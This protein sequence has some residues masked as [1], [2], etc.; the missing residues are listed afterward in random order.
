MHTYQYHPSHRHTLNFMR[1][2]YK[3][4]VFAAFAVTQFIPL[5]Q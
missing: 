1:R 2:Q 4:P 5:I 3:G